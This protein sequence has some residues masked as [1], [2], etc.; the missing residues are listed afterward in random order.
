[1]SK[2]IL[3]YLPYHQLKKIFA[4][5]E[6]AISEAN[7]GENWSDFKK[8]LNEIRRDGYSVSSG[9]FRPHITGVAAPVFNDNDLIV[10]S[11]GV[12]GPTPELLTENLGNTIEMVTRAANVVS[13]RLQSNILPPRAV[14]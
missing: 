7:L 14:G 3:P 1:M 10:G 13:E 5:S 12:A 8:T 9:E 4:K 11:V 6:A 2:I